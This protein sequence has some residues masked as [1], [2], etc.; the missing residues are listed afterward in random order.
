MT[1]DPQQTSDGPQEGPVAASMRAKLTAAFAP[2]RLE[3]EDESER[4]RGHAGFKEGG[5]THFK[6]LIE[7]AAFAGRSR[8]VNHRAVHDA[9]RE[10]L[11]SRV[12]ALSL[13]LIAPQAAD[14]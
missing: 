14:D 11:E 7:A 8:V 5:E 2:T 3:I 9:V 10:E 12:H 1:D 13:T 6:V 4:H